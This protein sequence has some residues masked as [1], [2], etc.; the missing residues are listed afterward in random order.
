MTSHVVLTKAGCVLMMLNEIHI[1]Y[2]K[3]E[4][5]SFDAGINLIPH[6][7]ISKLY[8]TRSDAYV[9]VINKIVSL[10]KVTRIETF[11][12]ELRLTFE[13]DIRR[14]YTAIINAK[15]CLRCDRNLRSSTAN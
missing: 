13:E 8:K 7:D 2:D 14:N 3:L 1:A 6:Y 9:K 10:S 15:G 4:L 12:K 11:I 5:L